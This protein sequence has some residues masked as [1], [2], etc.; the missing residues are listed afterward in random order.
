MAISDIFKYQAAYNTN[1]T[2]DDKTDWQD[3]FN[4]ANNFN[5]VANNYV[6]L[7]D[8]QRKYQEQ[9][10]TQPWRL[11]FTNAQNQANTA[12][13]QLDLTKWQGASQALEF[14]QQNAYKD[15]RFLTDAEKLELARNSAINPYAFSL[16][17]TAGRANALNNAK[18]LAYINPE[19]A[20][21]YGRNKGL[22]DNYILNGQMWTPDGQ[23]L[24]IIPQEVIA[25]YA[26]GNGY[27]A[28]EAAQKFNQETQK[29]YQLKQ[30]EGQNELEKARLQVQEKA[31]ARAYQ[32]ETDMLNALDKSLG[33]LSVISAEK[34]ELGNPTGKLNRDAFYRNAM[35][36]YAR[37]GGQQDKI[38]DYLYSIAQSQGW[39]PQASATPTAPKDTPAPATQ[40]AP[41]PNAVETPATVV[42][43]PPTPTVDIRAK[44]S[45]TDN[46][47]ALVN[48][49]QQAYGVSPEQ[50]LKNLAGMFALRQN[51]TTQPEELTKNIQR[52]IDNKIRSQKAN[53]EADKIRQQV[54]QRLPQFDL[55]GYQLD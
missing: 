42:T 49:Y 37:Y 48:A 40:T 14:N 15:G 11:A 5:S 36:L 23:S 54:L 39:L 28:S 20:S 26:V 47:M 17:E 13:E 9:I 43:P 16:I 33:N 51:G 32:R 50:A 19:Y 1:G 10:D 27:A 52:L 25:A 30:L 6:T 29:A 41:T 2:F 46:D 12:K 44:Y 18:N 3:A 21:Q 35:E 53:A 7:K 24:G 45:I 22:W 31:E 8:N 38:N 55:V 34:D 4:I